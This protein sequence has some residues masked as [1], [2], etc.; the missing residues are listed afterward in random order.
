MKAEANGVHADPDDHR[1]LTQT[2]T[3]ENAEAAENGNRQ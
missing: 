3:A 1:R 2:L